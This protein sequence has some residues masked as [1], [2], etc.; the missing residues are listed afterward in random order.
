MAAVWAQSD[1]V[2]AISII[3][4]AVVAALGGWV[5]LRSYQARRQV[6]RVTIGLS[7]LESSLKRAD[8]D[9]ELQDARHAEDLTRMEARHVEALAAMQRQLDA[10][11]AS[12]VA[13]N[14]RCDKKLRRLGHIV[15]ELGGKVPDDL[16]G[17]NAA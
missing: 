5:G 7:S 9:R 10:L 3:V 8:I 12:N 11:V 16:N 13:D 15:K 4:G 6:D 14:E 2:T 1:P 17:L